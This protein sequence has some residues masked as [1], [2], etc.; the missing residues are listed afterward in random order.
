[1]NRMHWLAL[2]A[3]SLTALA[4][5]GGG[6]AAS[7]SHGTTTA[8]AASYAGPIRSTD[9]ARGEGI[10][11]SLCMGCHGGGAPALPNLAW[12]PAAMRRQIREGEGRMPAFNAS[13]LNDDDLEAV[14]A[15]MVT[16][17]AVRADEAAAPAATPAPAQ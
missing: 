17:G 10:F 13:R 9:A 14:L 6:A 11:Q 12:T 2:G 3:V 16:I 8:S 1:M 5:C 15:H 7:G 4:G